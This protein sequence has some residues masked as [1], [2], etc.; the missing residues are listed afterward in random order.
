M[1]VNTRQRG[2]WAESLAARFLSGQGLEILERNYL[3]R[4]GELDLVCRDRDARCFVIVEVRFRRNDRHGGAIASVNHVKRQ[5][6]VRA[7]KTWLAHKATAGAAARIDV[8]G[9]EGLAVDGARTKD[10]GNRDVGSKSP[11]SGDPEN[12]RPANGGISPP[13][14]PGEPESHVFEG[15]RLVWLRN[16]VFD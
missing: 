3:R 1:I 7:A 5:R 16:A 13:S 6:L 9:I 14:L 12:Q 10:A 11:N 2:A 4:S 15:H 8:L